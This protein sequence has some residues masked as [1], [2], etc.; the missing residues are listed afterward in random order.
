MQIATAQN[1]SL[2][3]L[4]SE[5]ERKGKSPLTMGVLGL[6]LGGILGIFAAFLL[7]FFLKVKVARTQA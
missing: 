2:V 6:V 3:S 5:Y 7:E 1:T 4:A